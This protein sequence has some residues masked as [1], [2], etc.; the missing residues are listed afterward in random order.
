MFCLVLIEVL[1]F[2]MLHGFFSESWPVCY[3]A[4]PTNEVIDLSK[5]GYHSKDVFFRPVYLHPE[6]YAFVPSIMT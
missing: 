2:L 1:T 3:E 4:L 5:I 6:R